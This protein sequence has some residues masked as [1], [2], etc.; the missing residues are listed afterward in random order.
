MHWLHLALAVALEVLGTSLLQ[1]TVQARTW[2]PLL[3]TAATYG[4]AFYFLLLTLRTVPVGIAY[5]LWSGLGT[6]LVAVVDWTVFE[7]RLTAS[8]MVGVSLIIAGVVAIQIGAPM[9]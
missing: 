2:W 1:S 4:G 7:Q 8:A 5:A 3:G 6:A 9:R